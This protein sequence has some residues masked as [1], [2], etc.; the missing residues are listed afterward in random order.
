MCRSCPRHPV[1]YVPFSLQ[2]AACERVCARQYERVPLINVTYDADSV[3]ADALRR[4]AQV[5]PDVVAEAVACPEEPWTG[6]PE[7]GDIEIRFQQRSPYD[8]GGLAC[9]IEV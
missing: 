3:P 1:R 2:T 7:V 5:L 8:V 4:L 6:P 9:V